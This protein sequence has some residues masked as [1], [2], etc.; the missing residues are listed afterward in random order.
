MQ[1]SRVGMFRSLLVQLYK[2]SFS[3]RR[4]ILTAF[5]EKKLGTEERK[6]LV[7]TLDELQSLFSEILLSEQT[8]EKE[9]VI[10]I[11]ALDEVADEVGSR[12]APSLL[13]FFHHLNGAVVWKGAKT[14]ICISC[15]QY[16]VVAVNAGGLQISIQEE[17]RK[18]IER[19]VSSQLSLLVQDWS[20]Q[21]SGLRNELEKAMV[22]KADG[23][24]LWVVKRLARI[25]D[26]LNDGAVSLSDI[27]KLVESESNELFVLY[28]DIL[29]RDVKKGVWEKALLLMQWICLSERP[30]TL[31]EIR[32]AIACDD[33]SIKEG[34]GKIE[35]SCGY[36]ESD[37]RMEKLIRSLLGGLAEVRCGVV[38]LFHQSVTD[39]L[40][41]RGIRTLF[42]AT[43]DA[44]ITDWTDERI[45]GISQDRLSKSCFRYLG[46]G[47]VAKIPVW[48]SGLL[49]Q[50]F[51][52]VEGHFPFIRYATAYS[53][54]HAERAEA[55]GI[56]QE[57]L[58]EL[59]EPEPGAHEEIRYDPE[60]MIGRSPTVFETWKI[61]FKEIDGFQWRYP[62]VGSSLI[63][64]A[65]SFNLQSVIRHLVG[66]G[67]SVDQGD[68][69]QRTALHFAAR[70]G[71]E[72]TTSMLLDFGA[73]IEAKT[74]SG[75][76]PLG[77]AVTHGQDT[78]ARL[79][80]RRGAKVNIGDGQFANMLEAACNVKGSIGLVADLVG[81]GASING[82][83]EATSTA[84]QEA[85]YLGNEEVVRYLISKGADVNAKGKKYGS[86]LHAAVQ[87]P[88]S[89]L[90]RITR[91]LLDKK[92]N[93]N[94]QGG[95]FGNPLQAAAQRPGRDNT[96]IM[97]MLLNEGADINAQGGMFCTALQA[98]CTT[99]KVDSVKLLLAMGADVHIQGGKFG[100]ALQAA[101]RHNTDVVPL[102]L[103]HGADVNVEGGYYGSALQC[104]AASH[105]VDIVKMLLEHGA[106]VDIRG[107]FHGSA[108]QAAAWG[109]DKEIV[110]IFL[111]LGADINESG[112]DAGSA[113][114]AAIPM[115]T[116][117]FIRFLLD[118]GADVNL[119]G[120]GEGN[121]LRATLVWPREAII[122]LLLERGADIHACIPGKYDSAF[123]LALAKEDPKLIT[124]LLD[125]G[126]NNNPKDEWYKQAVER[127]KRPGKERI[128]E[129]LLRWKVQAE[130]GN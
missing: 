99:S 40:R 11:D 71:Y 38:Q 12:S 107:G 122:K 19:Y 48:A 114:Q 55:S 124:L 70:L 31:V 8:R 2:Q 96:H 126:K 26:D 113:L 25:V 78:V 75:R 59:L 106:R 115:C 80:I 50:K 29:R 43:I 90:G 108:L 64:V 72:S 130:L 61:V 54:V 119:Q 116:E 39:F 32:M 4:M 60:E 17:N 45:L 103:S 91:L 47:E 88:D 13:T 69:D 41:E 81:Y 52:E 46:L 118:K 22:D 24:F 68:Y 129:L 128:A 63:H 101:S 23:V 86:T 77:F 74:I 49:V 94:S 34:Q 42:A 62:D 5:N 53:F 84:L 20:V 66:S 83:V 28:E 123:Q 87:G 21:P 127:A 105:D 36:V 56:P 110:T 76:S 112:G 89:Q 98:A 120:G 44:S 9:V 100:T 51:P 15:R 16:P 58:V 10:F 27:K 93:V 7:W 1:K 95:E 30:L 85:A 125:H 104:A 73:D 67:C 111:D 37:E 65:A 14:K 82:H 35:D 102:L 97:M 18:D 57:Y 3:A 79:L 117:R 92:A 121:A 6:D 109:G 33:N